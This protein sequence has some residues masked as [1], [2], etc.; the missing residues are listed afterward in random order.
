MPLGEENAWP[1]ALVSSFWRSAADQCHDLHSR[2][3]TAI[4][5]AEEGKPRK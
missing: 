3:A 5:F 2:I 4:T 1:R